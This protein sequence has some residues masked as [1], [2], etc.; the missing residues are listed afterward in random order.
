MLYRHDNL[1]QYKADK[2]YI[3]LTFDDGPNRKYTPKIL[4]ILKKHGVKACF[5]LVGKMIKKNPDIVMRIFEEGHDIGNHTYTHPIKS[6]ELLSMRNK[7]PLHE[8]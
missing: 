5:F 6:L 4:D 8:F 3:S 1:K 7:T 2:S